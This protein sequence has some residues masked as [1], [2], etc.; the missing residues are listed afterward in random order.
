MLIVSFTSAPVLFNSSEKTPLSETSGTF[1]AT[2]ALMLP[3]M[4]AGVMTKKPVPFVTLT[5]PSAIFSVPFA[6]ATRT[7]LLPS[8]RVDCSRTKF[9][10]SVWP[11]TFNVAGTVPPMSTRKYGPAGRLRTVAG[12]GDGFAKV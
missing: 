7:A 5:M 8:A 12:N 10:L 2:L 9:A 4:P 11:S 6:M 1:S 3:A